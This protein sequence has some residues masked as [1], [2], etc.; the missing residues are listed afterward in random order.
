MNGWPS[1]IADDAG[2]DVGSPAGRLRH[3]D[4]DRPRREFLRREGTG[5]QADG[6]K[7]GGECRG[8]KSIEH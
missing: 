1:C 4:G 5:S 2:D 6:Y 7:R 8:M 3:D